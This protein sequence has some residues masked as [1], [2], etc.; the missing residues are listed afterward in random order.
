MRG[1]LRIDRA[2]YRGLLR[3]SALDP[4]GDRL[5]RGVE[6]ARRGGLAQP[7]IHHRT[8]HGLST[9]GRQARILVSVHSVLRES[10]GLATSAFPVRT[11]WTTS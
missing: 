2:S 8:Y 5:G 3:G 7:A 11:E 10:L 4:F 1:A 9:F 6:L